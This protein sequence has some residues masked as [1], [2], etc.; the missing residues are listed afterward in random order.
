MLET[1]CTHVSDVCPLWAHMPCL[2]PS[3][4][5]VLPDDVACVADHHRSVPD[6]V[7]VGRVALE[8]GA[9]NHHAPPVTKVWYRPREE[10]VQHCMRT[11]ASHARL[12]SKSP[13]AGRL[14]WLLELDRTT[15]TMVV[16]SC[17]RCTQAAAVQ[18]N[19]TQASGA[20]TRQPVGA[21]LHGSVCCPTLALSTQQISL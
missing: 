6:D 5:A 16:I 7:M 20:T 17:C 10:C 15:H 18:Q 19:T 12:R 9:H 1:A 11:C 8:D 13:G 3:H 21:P 2:C 14:G 4:L